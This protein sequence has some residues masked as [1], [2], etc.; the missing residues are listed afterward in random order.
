MQGH[1]GRQTDSPQTVCLQLVIASV[2][3]NRCLINIHISAYNRLELLSLFHSY[4]HC[5][6]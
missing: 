6:S 4:Y 1:T 3:T 5:S 2:G